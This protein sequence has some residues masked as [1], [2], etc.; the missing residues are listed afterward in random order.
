MIRKRLKY[1]LCGKCPGFA[2]TFPYYGTQ[3]YFP[4]DSISFRAVC[5]Q[6]I[7]EADNVRLLQ[8]LG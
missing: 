3:V 1:W 2:G 5:E 4:K 7:F 8:N 6:G